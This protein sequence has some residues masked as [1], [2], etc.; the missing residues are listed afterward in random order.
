MT[1]VDIENVNSFFFDAL[2]MT[3]QEVIGGTTDCRA[4]AGIVDVDAGRFQIRCRGVFQILP[5]IA[6]RYATDA[7]RTP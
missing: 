5:E 4:S 6:G 7:P 1:A 3:G 2:G